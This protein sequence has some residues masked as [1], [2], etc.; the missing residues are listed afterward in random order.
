MNSKRKILKINGEVLTNGKKMCKKN[1]S[2]RSFDM[3]SYVDM[4]RGYEVLEKVGKMEKMINK[5]GDMIC[6]MNKRIANIESIV[7][8][9]MKKDIMIDDLNHKLHCMK[10]DNDEL[11][12]K[13]EMENNNKDDIKDF[14]C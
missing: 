5:L 1:I 7:E 12:Y 2:K 4:I 6:I 13:L 3:G 9:D 14:Y 10:I 11:K 8:K